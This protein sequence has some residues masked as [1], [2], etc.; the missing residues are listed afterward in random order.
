MTPQ[1]LVAQWSLKTDNDWWLFKIPL[2]DG[3]R[4][5]KQSVDKDGLISPRG[6]HSWN[7]LWA[8]WWNIKSFWRI[9]WGILIIPLRLLVFSAGVPNTINS[10]VSANFRDTCICAHLVRQAVFKLLFLNRTSIFLWS[11]VPGAIHPA[12]GTLV[13]TGQGQQCRASERWEDNWNRWM[14]CG[15]NVGICADVR[16]LRCWMSILAISFRGFRRSECMVELEP[17]LD[18]SSTQ[19]EGFREL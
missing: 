11:T 17:R 2:T 6:D 4:L 1:P 13:S 7:W 10:D 16:C 9:R 8:P 18:F 12:H 15:W 5:T 19:R 3:S 14:E